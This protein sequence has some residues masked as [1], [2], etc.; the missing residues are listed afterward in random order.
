MIQEDSKVYWLHDWFG[1]SHSLISNNEEEA[2][3]DP[4]MIRTLV[5]MNHEIIN[6]DLASRT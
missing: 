6:D 2:P 3:H 5:T 4:A 1:T